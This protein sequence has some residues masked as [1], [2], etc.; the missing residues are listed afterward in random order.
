MLR[1]LVRQSVH[2]LEQ[3]LV[4][5]KPLSLDEVKARACEAIQANP[6][7]WRD[8]EAIAGEDGPP[9]EEQDLL[10]ELKNRIRSSNSVSQILNALFDEHLEG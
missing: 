6:D 9:R 4:E 2:K 7:D 1:A 8:D 3:E 5:L 10:D